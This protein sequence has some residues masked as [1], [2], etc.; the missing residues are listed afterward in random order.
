MKKS[1]HTDNSGKAAM[2]DVADKD[3]TRRHARAT[4]TVKLNDGTFQAVR[5]NRSKKGDILNT[6]RLAGIQAA[7]KTAELIP[8]CHPLPLDFI[9]IDFSLVEKQKLVRIHSVVKCTSRTGVEMEALTACSVAALTI[10][11]M[12]KSI[13]RDIEITDLFLVEKKGGKSGEYSRSH[14]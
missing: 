10:Y 12:L 4:I 6:A 14:P 13:Q 11:D 7:K 8:L 3:V 5:D 9:S 2:V 1:S